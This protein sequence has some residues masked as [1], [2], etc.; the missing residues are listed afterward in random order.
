MK[1]KN[2]HRGALLKSVVEK[3]DLH[4]T[5]IVKRAH[6]SRGSYYIHITQKDL[7]LA[8]MARYSQALS[9]DFST[10]L[11]EIIPYIN[12]LEPDLDYVSIEGLRHEVDKYRNKYVALLEKY[13]AMLESYRELEQRIHELEQ[14]LRQNEGISA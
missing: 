12:T 7:S 2:I 4:I 14:R 1:E 5:Q 3:S 11:P 10:E 6:Y 9:Y 8:I 13:Q